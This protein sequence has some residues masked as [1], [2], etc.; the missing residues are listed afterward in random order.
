MSAQVV[1]KGNL[2]QEPELRYTSKGTAL[3]RFGVAVDRRWINKTS[4]QQ[5][6]SVSFFEVA[7]WE[8]LA[9]HCAASLRKGM[10]VIVEGR[11]EQDSW[12]GDDGVKRSSVEVRADDVGPS[13]RWQEAQVNSV[14]RGQPAGRW[15][16]EPGKP[17]AAGPTP[18][19]STET[20]QTPPAD[21][22]S[23]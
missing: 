12:V 17:S 5:E 16:M 22:D 10:R 21:D 23:F 20:P 11:L 19:V 3:V 7:A 2:T 1:I 8:T 6:E 9:E 18:E 4:G 15:D 13:L 14:R